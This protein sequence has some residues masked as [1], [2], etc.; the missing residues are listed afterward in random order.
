MAGRPSY[1]MRIDVHGVAARESVIGNVDDR[2][3]RRRTSAGN[4]DGIGGRKHTHCAGERTRVTGGV[5]LAAVE[6][7]GGQRETGRAMTARREGKR[8]SPRD[9]EV[10]HIEANRTTVHD[11]AEVP[12][13]DSE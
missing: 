4:V 12:V 2:G 11:R 10:S 1:V 7:G 6:G 5:D 8:L 3:E 13:M 9:R